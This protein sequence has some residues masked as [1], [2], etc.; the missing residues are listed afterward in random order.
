VVAHRDRKDGLIWRTLLRSNAILNVSWAS[1]EPGHRYG[2]RTTVADAGGKK[3]HRC[4]LLEED[5]GPDP[6]S[7]MKV[8]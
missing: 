2:W 4:F 8:G 1:M 6:L 7:E 3:V 5:A